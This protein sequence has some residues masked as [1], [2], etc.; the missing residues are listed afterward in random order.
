[1]I[2]INNVCFPEINAPLRTDLDFRL[3]K[4]ENFHIGTT[5]VEEIPNFDLINN[6][7]LDYMHLVCLGV[8]RRL[9]Y[10][11]LFGDHKFRL[12]NRKSQSILSNLENIFKINVLCE[13]VRKPRSLTYVKLWK[14]TEYREL[15][16]YTGPVVFK[17]FLC[18]D[19]YNHFVT[20]HVA[21]RILCSNKLQNLFNYYQELLEHFVKTFALI[22]GTHNVS[23]NVHGLIHFIKDVK[24]FGPLDHFSAF[25]YENYLQTLK[26]LLK[27]YDK[28]LQ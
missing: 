15:L 24:K 16:L 28:S 13:F 18:S 4:D 27:K 14:A 19:I 23:Y 10:L 6:I 1:M 20:L 5:S 17:N 22:Y 21:I 26:K 2:S 12:E 8:T 3:K 9:L 11:W 25:K 7:L